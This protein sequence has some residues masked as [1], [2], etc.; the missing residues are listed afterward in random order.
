MRLFAVQDDPQ[1]L[2]QFLIGFRSHWFASQGFSLC[3]RMTY[4]ICKI[5]R[6]I[7]SHGLLLHYHWPLS[8]VHVLTQ[9]IILKAF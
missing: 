9:S 2:T 3:E 1:P 8:Q 4:S 6:E 5:L 7:E